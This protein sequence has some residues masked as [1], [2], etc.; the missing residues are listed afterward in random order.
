M[1]NG[2][3]SKIGRL[4]CQNGGTKIFIIY[5]QFQRQDKY[6]LKTFLYIWVSAQSCGAERGYKWPLFKNFFPKRN[7]F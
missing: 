5:N 3:V 1:N 7:N 2:Y 4:P 6:I